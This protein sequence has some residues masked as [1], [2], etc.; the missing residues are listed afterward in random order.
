MLGSVLAFMYVI[1]AA[2]YS[3]LIIVA[4]YRSEISYLIH[5]LPRAWNYTTLALVEE[6][7]TGYQWC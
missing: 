7:Q 3:I 6:E 2:P 1:T 5:Y 4:K